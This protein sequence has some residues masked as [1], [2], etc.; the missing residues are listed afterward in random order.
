MDNQE[1][2]ARE[3]LQ[4]VQRYL[5]ARLG[6]EYGR[7]FA[8]VA[9]ASVLRGWDGRGDVRDVVFNRVARVALGM[10]R[11]QRGR[12]GSARE[13]VNAAQS[14]YGADAV[15]ALQSLESREQRPDAAAMVESE[16]FEG[17][18]TIE[19]IADAP[20]RDRALLAYLAG[21][22]LTQH[23]TPLALGPVVYSMDELLDCLML[24]GARLDLRTPTSDRATLTL[25]RRAAAFRMLAWQRAVCSGNGVETTLASGEHGCQAELVYRSRGDIQKLFAASYVRWS[26]GVIPADLQLTLPCVAHWALAALLKSPHPGRPLLFSSALLHLDRPTVERFAAQLDNLIGVPARIVEWTGCRSLIIAADGRA[27][28]ETFLSECGIPWQFLAGKT[29][30]FARA[31]TLHCSADFEP[32]SKTECREIIAEAEEIE[33][34]A[35]AEPVVEDAEEDLPYEAVPA[36]AVEEVPSPAAE[37]PEPAIAPTSAKGVDFTRLTDDELIRIA[38]GRRQ[39]NEKTVAIARQKIADL[40][41]INVTGRALMQKVRRTIRFAT[42]GQ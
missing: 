25:R 36:P 22:P 21:V 24:G 9:L 3:L 2:I 4:E 28:V 13:R 17:L 26:A 11:E 12:K 10:L 14:L 31:T 8:G 19:S 34:D 5:V 41:A 16:F 7:E 15:E 39:M 1:T 29:D 30:L 33:Q 23:A 37:T 27:K 18:Q 38:A 35:E 6:V 20:R 42:E 32:L 40:K